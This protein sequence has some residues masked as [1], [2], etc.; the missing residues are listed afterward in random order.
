M[1]PSRFSWPTAH[2]RHWVFTFR[3]PAVCDALSVPAPAGSM[4]GS[5]EST[6]IKYL[7]DETSKPPRWPSPAYPGLIGDVLPEFI[8]F[9]GFPSS[10]P[11]RASPSPPST[12]PVGTSARSRHHSSPRARSA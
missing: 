12:R 5:A 9:S 3:F 11:R 8:S 6:S 1:V 4:D 7:D 10:S 2:I